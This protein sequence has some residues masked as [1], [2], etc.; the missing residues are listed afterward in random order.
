MAGTI[1][2]DGKRILIVKQ[3]SL[4]DIVHTLPVVHALK[5]CHPTCRIG[6]IA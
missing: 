2:L 5:R 3:S 6:W 4:G 1:D